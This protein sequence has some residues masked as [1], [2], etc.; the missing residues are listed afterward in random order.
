MTLSNFIS[1][2]QRNP[3]GFASAQAIATNSL[4]NFVFDDSGRSE[5]LSTNVSATI[6]TVEVLS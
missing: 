4:G 5:V 6:I 2:K 3:V 1:T